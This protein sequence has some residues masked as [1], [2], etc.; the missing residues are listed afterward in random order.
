V[1]RPWLGA[2]L[3][4]AEQP[5]QYATVRLPR[6]P[7]GTGY[8]ATDWLVAFA[9]TDR[10][11]QALKLLEFV[12]RDFCQRE[13]AQVGGVPATRAL[14]EGLRGTPRWAAHIQGLERARGLP[15]GEWIR[16]KA[17]LANA[18]TYALSGRRGV[19]EALEQA[20]MM[21]F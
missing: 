17:Q 11:E 16:L 10:R 4:G 21:E 5:V 14:A 13:L 18:L 9:N 3:G 8:V 20:E 6:E 1:G 19:H 2:M 12:A 7:G 15:P